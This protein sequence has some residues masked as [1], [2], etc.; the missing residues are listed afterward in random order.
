[1]LQYWTTLRIDHPSSNL[2]RM[3][4]FAFSVRSGILFVKIDK[5]CKCILHCRK[6]GVLCNVEIN[7]TDYIAIFS[8]FN[9]FVFHDLLDQK[10]FE[11]Y[12]INSH[13]SILTFRRFYFKNMVVTPDR[14]YF[15]NSFLIN[16]RKNIIKTL[17]LA[18]QKTTFS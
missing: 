1:M 12:G 17:R 3:N 10:F 14:K 9:A 15:F 6:L 7:C 8:T 4:T 2:E 18:E 16:L 11:T 5:K 13:L